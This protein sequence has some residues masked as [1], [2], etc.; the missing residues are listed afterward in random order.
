MHNSTLCSTVLKSWSEFRKK[1]PKKRNKRKS[2]WISAKVKEQCLR[3]F[4][5]FP[6]NETLERREGHDS[7]Q[8]WKVYSTVGTEWRKYGKNYRKKGGKL[9]FVEFQP[10]WTYSAEANSKFFQR[11]RHFRD[12]RRTRFDAEFKALSNCAKKM[13]RKW[14]KEEKKVGNGTIFWI[15]TKAKQQWGRKLWVFQMKKSM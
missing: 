10:K 4:W 5:V 13:K 7:M 2:R 11:R 14:Q 9:K 6:I 3:K 12:K 15:S 1:N 8:N